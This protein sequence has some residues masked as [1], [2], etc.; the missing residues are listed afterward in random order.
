MKLFIQVCFTIT[1]LMFLGISAKAGPVPPCSIDEQC[2]DDLFCTAPATCVEG[3][4]RSGGLRCPASTEGCV[5]FGF[6]DEENDTCPGVPNDSNCAEGE[7]CELATGNCIEPPSGPIVIIPTMGQWG[8]IF[9]SIIL[10][11]FAVVAL[12]RRIKS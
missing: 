8:M 10:G 6:C 11:I 4:C 3:S 2:N 7:I 12:R 1:L 9:A 5:E